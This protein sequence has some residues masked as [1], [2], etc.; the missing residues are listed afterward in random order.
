LLAGLRDF[1]VPDFV[2][3]E[4]TR[5]VFVVDEA[6]RPVFVVD[7]ATR[8]VLVVDEATRPRGLTAWHESGTNLISNAAGGPPCKWPPSVVHYKSPTF[9]RSDRGFYFERYRW[10]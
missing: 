10:W 4:A 3:D 9:V 7:E 2:V 1:F 8:P 6:T 5:P